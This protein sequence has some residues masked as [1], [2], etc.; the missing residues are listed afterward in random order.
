MSGGYFDYKQYEI[1]NI[2]FEIEKLIAKNDLNEKDKLGSEI[3][4]QYK[5]ETISKFRETA[6]L[7]R[8]AA[9]MVKRI[10]WLI[11]YDDGEENFHHHWDEEMSKIRHIISRL[12]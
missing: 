12:T 7:L 1:K 2:A 10:D 3:G 9:K 8:I 5:S 4:Y 6:K 11:S